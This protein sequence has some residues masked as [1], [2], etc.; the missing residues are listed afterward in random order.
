MRKLMKQQR[1]PARITTDKLRPYEFA[2]KKLGLVADHVTDKRANSR[3]ENLHQPVRRRERK[4]QRLKSPGSARR[5]FNL[6]TA[7]CNGFY[8]RRHLLDRTILKQYRKITFAGWTAA[9]A[10]A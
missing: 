7:T 9:C 5:F 4:L 1:A 6:P 8:H 2:F 10:E 3:A